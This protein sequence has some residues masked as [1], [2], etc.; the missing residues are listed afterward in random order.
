[1]TFF[2]KQNKL[3][4]ILLSIDFEKAF[5]SFNWNF[6]FKT[7]EH[8]NFEKNFVRYVKTMYNNIES[9]VVNNGTTCKYFKLQ[10]GVREGCLLSAYLFITALETLANKLRKYTRLI[11]RK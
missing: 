4:G 5:N 6:L 8:V 2:T 9:T 7:L 1:M 3:P 11:I 10:Q